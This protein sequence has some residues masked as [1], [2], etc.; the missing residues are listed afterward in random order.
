M[1]PAVEWDLGQIGYQMRVLGNYWNEMADSRLGCPKPQNLTDGLHEAAPSDLGPLCAR[2]WARAESRE[3][4]AC[5]AGEI[6]QDLRDC[7]N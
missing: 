2:V 7:T 6:A 5:E 3:A 1:N 4:R